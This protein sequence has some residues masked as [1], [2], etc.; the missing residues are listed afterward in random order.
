[1]NIP[2]VNFYLKHV[3]AKE[4]TLISMQ[5]K[6]P[7]EQRVVIST[8]DKIHPE[9]WDFTKQRAVVNRKSPRNAETNLWLDKIEGDVKSIFR[10]LFIDGIT[11]T[12]PIVREKLLAALDITPVKA[13]QK[14]LDLLG[15]IEEFMMQSAV[16]KTKETIKS[17]RTTLNHLRTFATENKH[18]VDFED[19]TIDFY[20]KITGYLQG[21]GNSKNTI[22]KQIKNLKTFMGEATERGLNN[23]MDFRS[24][25]FKKVTEEVD[26]IYL[27]EEEIMRMYALT[28]PKGKERVRDLFI[29]SCYTGLRYSDFS[30]ITPD[31]ILH[32]QIHMRT[33]KTGEKVIIPLAPI[34]KEILAKYDYQLPTAVSNQ[35]MN[36]YLKDIGEL[37]GID[38]PIIITRTIGGTRVRTTYK[39]FQLISAHCGRRSMATNAYKRGVPSI[40]LMKITGHSTEKA[41]MSYI[42]ISQLENAEVLAKHDFFQFNIL[43]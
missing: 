24:R 13:E 12:A 4:P 18:K 11:P 34:V 31:N 43:K 37:A 1:M 41:F 38:D 23:N 29:I 5:I 15:F 16:S 20:H 8:G 27:T 35:K 25:S 22:S 7:I 32:D 40:S 30:R 9:E 26:K 17:Y 28:L 2:K 3:G 39:K 42:R 21:I 14:K 19:I 10:N 33:Q 36:E 6:F